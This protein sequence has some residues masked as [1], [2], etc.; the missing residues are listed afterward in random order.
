MTLIY[1]DHGVQAKTKSQVYLKK[2]RPK[3]SVFTEL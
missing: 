2:T 1:R 3:I